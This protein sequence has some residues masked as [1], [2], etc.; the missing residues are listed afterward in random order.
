MRTNPVWGGLTTY[1]WDAVQHF[2]K[3][4]WKRVLHPVLWG[5]CIWPFPHMTSEELMGVTDFVCISTLDQ[6]RA[7]ILTF[8]GRAA[9]KVRV[10]KVQR[11]W[12]LEVRLQNLAYFFTSIKKEA[13]TLQGNHALLAELKENT[14]L[15]ENWGSLVR[16]LLDLIQK[17]DSDFLTM[18]VQNVWGW[19][20][21]GYLKSLQHCDSL[22]HLTRGVW[23]WLSSV[24]VPSLCCSL[25]RKES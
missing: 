10:G 9:N 21:S 2:C 16:C 22:K 14:F 7:L 8:N 4:M 13:S 18:G 3:F 6:Q 24:T 11:S 12:Q 25:R 20:Q 17:G 15:L 23:W 19:K 1:F 5:F